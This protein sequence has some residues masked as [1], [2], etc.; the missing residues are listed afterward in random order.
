M[1]S[2]TTLCSREL[3]KERMLHDFTILN[4]EVAL[5]LLRNCLTLGELRHLCAWIRLQPYSAERWMRK[6]V[7]TALLEVSILCRCTSEGAAM[8]LS[9]KDCKYWRADI[10]VERYDMERD[11]SVIPDVFGEYVL[12][13]NGNEHTYSARS[14]CTPFLFPMDS[15]IRYVGNINKSKPVRMFKMGGKLGWGMPTGD[16]IYS[17][18]ALSDF[19]QYGELKLSNEGT[20]T[21]R[22]RYISRN[23][24]EYAVLSRYSYSAKNYLSLMYSVEES[25]R[26]RESLL[27][28]LVLTYYKSRVRAFSSL[29]P[30]TEIVG[31]SVLVAYNKRKRTKDVDKSHI[32]CFRKLT[33]AQLMDV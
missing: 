3:L 29:H 13:N 9:E 30:T 4:S 11:L 20:R 8:M 18:T 5:L 26:R 23:E 31:S 32:L 14:G 1:F 27:R 12:L 6:G 17:Y 33:Y 25:I 7:L 22:K 15:R 16:R 19:A 24:Y 2:L 10:L 28:C 21:I